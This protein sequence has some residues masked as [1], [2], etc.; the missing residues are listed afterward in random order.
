[1][2]WEHFEFL[3]LMQTVF[4]KEFATGEFHCTR[5]EQTNQDIGIWGNG[6]DRK[7]IGVCRECDSFILPHSM[8]YWGDEGVPG[9]PPKVSVANMDGSN[10][11]PLM[12]TSI[13]LRQPSHLA[14]DTNSQI[15][16]VSDTYYYKVRSCTVL[17]CMFAP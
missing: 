16:Y 7:K 11:H 15:L 9:V 3:R 5:S 4:V 17:S 14:L 6:K 1:M 8:L 10:A 12:M 13:S 2:Q